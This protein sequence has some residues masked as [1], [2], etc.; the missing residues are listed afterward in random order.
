MGDLK[1]PCQDLWPDSQAESDLKWETENPL[2]DGLHRQD[3]VDQKSR[4]LTHA[5]GPA[6]GAEATAFATERD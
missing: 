1:S 3:G 2:S 4:S 6:T 5:P